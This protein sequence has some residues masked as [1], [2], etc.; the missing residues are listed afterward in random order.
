MGINQYQSND[1]SPFERI[2]GAV[3]GVTGT[4]KNFKDLSNQ[5]RESDQANQE[6]D[7][8]SDISKFNRAFVSTQTNQPIAE[9]VSARQLKELYPL[10]AIKNDRDF[11]REIS[12]RKFQQEKDLQGRKLESEKKAGAFL[13]PGQKAADTSFAKDASEYFYGGGKSTVDKNLGRLGGA[14][15]E[16]QKNPNITGGITTRIPGLASDVAQDTLN[17]EMA[18]VRDD[19]RASIQG[20]LRQVLGPQFTEKEGEAIFNRAFNPRLSGA[21][22]ARRAKAE[23]DALKNMAAQ[24]EQSM[25]QFMQSG[26]LSGFSPK[27]AQPVEMMK[28]SSSAADGEAQA[29]MDWLR[30]NPNHPRA[31]A[32]MEKLKTMGVSF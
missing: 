2:L 11:Q 30:A 26:T 9:T 20:T 24:K 5:S 7:P 17:P 14:I 19:I 32:V 13:T 15:D 25:Q 31:Q 22:N 4:I 21:E 18:K 27:S 6:A 3:Q 29:A 16:L 12:D 8:N 23:L 28:S 10:L 1:R